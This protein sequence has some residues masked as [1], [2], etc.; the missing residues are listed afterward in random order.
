MLAGKDPYEAKYQLL[1][2]KKE[3]KCLKHFNDCK[4]CIEYSNDK[5]G[6]YKNIEKYNLAKKCKMLIVFDDMI[7]DI[8]NNKKFNLIVT[9]VFIRGRKLNISFVFLIQSYFA[10]PK[11]IRLNFTHY[12]ILKI[13]HKQEFSQILFNYS[14]DIDF[15]NFM[16]LYK[17]YTV[18]PY[19]FLVIDTTLVSDNPSCFGNDI[20]ERI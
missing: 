2:N 12:F 3:F 4:A 6:I 17:K 19:P 20:L 15:R 1:T 9:E 10:V 11:N 5:N 14:S 13:P 7:A 16:N 18:K 8:L